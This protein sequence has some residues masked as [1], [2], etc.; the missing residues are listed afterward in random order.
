VIEILLITVIIGFILVIQRLGKLIE[1]TVQI[2]LELKSARGQLAAL[3]GYKPVAE[4]PLP[5]PLTLDE[6]DT[7]SKET[8]AQR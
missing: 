6:S 5:A 3:R 4:E 8:A 1:I 2:V 7:A